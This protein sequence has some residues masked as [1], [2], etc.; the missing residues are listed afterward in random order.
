V[1]KLLGKSPLAG[2]API[3]SVGGFPRAI[4]VCIPTLISSDCKAGN[5]SET[6]TGS[7]DTTD[8]D[9]GGYRRD[10]LPSEVTGSLSALTEGGI[11]GESDGGTARVY[12]NPVQR[13]G[14]TFDI[15][16]ARSLQP[17]M[18]WFLA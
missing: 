5:V 10:L 6:S 18:I 2:A 13:L 17:P 1:K 15:L 9:S 14:D 3:I 11:D 12:Q 8:R 16:T 7:R 4:S